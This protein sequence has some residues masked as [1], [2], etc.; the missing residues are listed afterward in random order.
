M[1]V[2]T[3]SLDVSSGSADVEDAASDYE[4]SADALRAIHD[5]GLRLARGRMLPPLALVGA[6]LAVSLVYDRRARIPL[7]F[8]VGAL[9]GSVASTL[10]ST[11]N[12]VGA[13]GGALALAGYLFAAGLGPTTAP[14]WM[15]RYLVRVFL[16]TAVLGAIGFFFIDNAA[17]IGGAAAGLALGTIAK[18]VRH[19]ARWLAIL[20]GCGWIAALVLIAGAIFTVGRL[21]AW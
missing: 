11:A 21:L 18:R 16:G 3:A 6:A 19:R 5:D 15:K 9:A 14:E 8:L 20:D 12:S 13:S 2:L 1:S 4:P 17:H 7:I 10:L